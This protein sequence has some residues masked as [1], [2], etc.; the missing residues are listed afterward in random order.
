MA[1]NLQNGQNNHVAVRF[2]ELK[3]SFK[4]LSLRFR[5][6]FKRFFL[7]MKVVSYP[8]LHRIV[9]NIIPFLGSLDVAKILE[10][11]IFPL[12]SWLYVRHFKAKMLILILIIYQLP[13][14][15]TILAILK[16]Y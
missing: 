10:V 8:K 7:I 1:R 9:A 16:Q 14:N 11:F 12:I 5:P 6:T 13:C 15:V 4:C 3:L 2:D